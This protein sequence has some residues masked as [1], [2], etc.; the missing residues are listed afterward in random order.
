MAEA[1]DIPEWQKAQQRAQKHRQK[2]WAVPDLDD[3]D[4]PVQHT[5]TTHKDAEVRWLRDEIGREGTGLAGFYRRGNRVATCS[6]IGSEGYIEPPAVRDVEYVDP[7]T[8]E[9]RKR[10]PND[11]GPATVTT[12]SPS[13]ITYTLVNRYRIQRWTGP[14]DDKRLTGEIYPEAW[15]KLVLSEP[16]FAPNLRTLQGVS[17]TPMVRAD[18]T[19]VTSAGF[20]TASG[21]LV[22]PTVEVPPVPERPTPAD[23]AKAKGWIDYMLQDFAWAHGDHD[24]ANYIG[25]MLTPLVRQL[26]DAAPKMGAMMA[27][28]PGSGKSLLAEILRTLHGGVFRSEMPYDEAELSKALMGILTQTTAPVVC[29]DNV[30][31]TL[32]SGKLSGLLTSRDYS[33]RVLGSTNE[34]HAVNDR[35]WI[36]TGNNLSVHK[37]YVRRMTWVT[38]DPNDPHPERRV[39]FEI[40]NLSQWAKDNRAALLW[41]LLVLI[42]SWNAADRP[43]GPSHGRD[44]FDPWQRVVSG[45]LRHAEIPGE[46]DNDVTI[47]QPVSEEDEELA[48]FL[49]AVVGA[50]GVGADWQTK[51]LVVL[52]MPSF[53]LPPELATLAASLP[54]AIT[55]ARGDRA[56]VAGHWVRK[57]VGSFA[58]GMC[59]RQRKHS[60]GGSAVF[61]VQT[62]S[63]DH[64]A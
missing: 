38:I 32:K 44:S 36:I 21:F 42:A 13:L 51:D 35:L 52:A 10:P 57:Q 48:R 24:R 55:E 1:A 41:S 6:R 50:W 58:D 17:H 5:L 43:L 19:I 59:V 8:G 20:D 7:T 11:N 64:G 23:V 37:D 4:V 2:V 26:S 9:V 47:G 15:A 3:A 39:G 45:I 22:L 49:H 29:F 53:S 16:E 34:V 27:H 56:K 14:K 31:G 40:E 12:A 25:L 33:D 54:S 46:F 61:Y 60:K 30:T 63:S 62:Q 18:G 28:Q